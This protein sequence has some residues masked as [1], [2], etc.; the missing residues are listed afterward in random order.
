LTFDD[1]LMTV[2]CMLLQK[3]G[4]ITRKKI[5]EQIAGQEGSYLLA[6][7]DKQPHLHEDVAHLFIVNPKN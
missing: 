4:C 1:Y 3:V 2:G 6:S 5:A 7:K